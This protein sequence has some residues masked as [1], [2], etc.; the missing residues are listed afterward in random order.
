MK[1]TQN[2]YHLQIRKGKVSENTLRWNALL[3]A[4]LDGNC[5]I[6]TEIRKKRK[7]QTA[8]V[9]SIDGVTEN[10]PE[11]FASIYDRLYNSL[12]E[13]LRLESILAEIVDSI[14]LSD[15]EEVHKI[16]AEK[17]N[18]AVGHLKK[19]KTDPVIQST[20]DCL[21]NARPVSVEGSAIVI[22]SWLFHGHIT[23]M[24]LLS[25]LVP[26]IKYKLGRLCSSD[27][28][29]SIAISSLIL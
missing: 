5:D 18:E 22:R 16:D 20:S 19:N 21:S 25:T 23:E 12:D 3:D 9:H 4:S 2:V 6:F 10:D 17:I 11:H 7:I 15:E 24:L 29:R 14:S 27:N 26:I 13:K 28:Y 1:R 8:A